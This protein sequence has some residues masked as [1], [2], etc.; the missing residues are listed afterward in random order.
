MFLISSE[1][2]LVDVFYIHQ[3]FQFLLDDISVSL[4]I[5]NLPLI[6]VFNLF[7]GLLNFLLFFN[8]QTFY[9]FRETILNRFKL[10]YQERRILKDLV[11]AKRYLH[12]KVVPMLRSVWRTSKISSFLRKYLICFSLCNLQISKYVF[13]LPKA[14]IFW[15]F[16]L[17][18]NY[19]LI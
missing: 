5:R 7:D 3:R 19:L 16:I 15:F 17:R 12:F 6:F 18:L 4:N 13:S 14:V 11:E 2:F 1:S 10:C 9:F 8:I